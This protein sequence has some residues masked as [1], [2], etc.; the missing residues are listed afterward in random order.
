MK[1]FYILFFYVMMGA[2]ISA[3]AQQD[4]VLK[5]QKD[6]IK[7]FS[8]ARSNS[9]FNEIKVET[10]VKAKLSDIAALI[11]DIDNYFKWSYNTKVSYTLKKVSN[12]EIFF[13]TEVN[14]PWPAAN[15]DLVVHLHI[16]QDPLSKIITVKN[17]GVPD[18]I[19]AKKD[20]VR[21]SFSNETWLIIPVDGTTVKIEY[22]LQVDPGESA[23]AWLVNLFAAKAPLES[24][25]KFSIQ[26]QQPKYTQATIPFIKN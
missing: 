26:L 24:F 12:D 6:S 19:P 4:W 23:P 7:V 13:Y 15:R 8:R 9:K 11:L 25:S 22:F 1:R 14:S 21:V 5:K 18:Y 2:A 16:T 17:I 20:I 3:N 10:T